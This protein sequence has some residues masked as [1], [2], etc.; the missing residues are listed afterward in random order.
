M[1]ELREMMT[2]RKNGGRRKLEEAVEEAGK[3]PFARKIQIAI[4]LPK[5]NLPVF[6][7]IF[8][9]EALQWFEG[10]PV[11]TIRSFRH[12][13]NVFL[14]QY[15]SNNMSIPGIDTAFGLRRR[16]F[17]IKDT[18]TMSELPEFQED[19]IALEEKQ[20]EVESYPVA[21]P[22]ANTGNAILLPRMTNVVASTSQGNKGK[23]ST[24]ME[25]KL[26]AMG[27]EDQE[28]LERE[29]KEAQSQARGR[30]NKIQRMDNPM[31]GYGGQQPYHNKRQGTGKVVWE[32]ISLPKLNTTVDKIWEAVIL[33]EKIPEPHNVG[34][35]PPPSRRSKEFCV[36]HLFRGHTTSNCR[37]VRK[38]TL[39][40]IDQGKL[41][42]FLI[43]QPQ[44]LPPPPSGGNAYGEE[45]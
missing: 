27:S 15:I 14:G 42:H 10:L 41:N 2:M 44:N 37:N 3:T 43:Q 12:L 20:R 33:M 6:T 7:S 34:Y 38:I 21:M 23:K 24:K 4:I 29:Y 35:E 1:A 26:V 11:G 28:E 25:Q 19:H 31:E 22:N 9:G 5:C 36:Y 30:N 18:I 40:M 16:I 13:Q 45:R 17:R 32:Q 39:R 8:D